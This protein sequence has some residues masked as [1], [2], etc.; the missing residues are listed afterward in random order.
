MFVKR[1]LVIIIIVGGVIFAVVSGL[2]FFNNL[3][4]SKESIIQYVLSNQYEL[5]EYINNYDWNTAESNSV[6][7]GVFRVSPW[8]EATMIQFETYSIGL[9]S[10]ASYKGFYYVSNDNPV[11]FQGVQ[12]S[13]SACNS[14]LYWTDGTDNWEYVEKISNK[15]YWF[16]AH[17]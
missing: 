15:W 3:L 13:F 12:L 11:G 5:E 9:G 2:L 6:R 4:K 10:G 7:Y 8:N 16:E 17:F 14:G 1:K